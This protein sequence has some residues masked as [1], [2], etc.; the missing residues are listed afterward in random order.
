MFSLVIYIFL[1]LNFVQGFSVD[2]KCVAVSNFFCS[3]FSSIFKIRQSTSAIKDYPM[4]CLKIRVASCNLWQS[5]PP[6]TNVQAFLLSVARSLF[7]QIIYAHRKSFEADKY[8]VIKS[9]LGSFQKNMITVDNIN[10]VLSMLASSNHLGLA[11]LVNS[12]IKPVL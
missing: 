4:H 9:L 12:F 6:V 3:H 5:C 10:D 2:L 1:L 7:Q 11:S 8:A